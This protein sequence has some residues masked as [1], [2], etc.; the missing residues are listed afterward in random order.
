M[1]AVFTAITFGSNANDMPVAVVAA[2]ASRLV[3]LARKLAVRGPVS[4][5]PEDTRRTASGCSPR[6]SRAAG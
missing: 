6:P 5:V 1:E 3:V 2:V 4:R